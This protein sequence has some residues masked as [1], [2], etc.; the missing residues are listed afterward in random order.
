MTT[1]EG[2]KS[3]T[4]NKKIISYS[5]NVKQGYSIWIGALAR[6]DFLSGEDKVLT[7]FFS[8]NVTIHKTS[9]FN[10]EEIFNKHAGTL[11][12]PIIS[13]NINVNYRFLN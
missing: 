4:I 7:F 13:K 10:A 9:L 11:L 1:W 5:M 12:R 2:I 6:L 8:H 3:V